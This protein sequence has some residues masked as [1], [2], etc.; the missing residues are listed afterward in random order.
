[1]WRRQKYQPSV[2]KANMQRSQTPF[3]EQGE[4]TM[5]DGFEVGGEIEI[6][7]LPYSTFL[8]QSTTEEERDYVMREVTDVHLR[9]S[10]RR[11]FV[12]KVYIF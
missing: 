10:A 8:K 3:I 1:M 7:C 11:A 9:A 6:E 5:L 2:Y 4:T 12:V